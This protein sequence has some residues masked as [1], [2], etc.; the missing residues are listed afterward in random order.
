MSRE[1]IAKDLIVRDLGLVSYQQTFQQMRDFTDSRNEQTADELWVLQHH[2]VFTQGQA[3]KAEHI[4]N[5]GSV[6]IVQSDRG[7]QV[8]YHGPGQ[9]V[10]YLLFDIK[11]KHL[12]IR[13]LVDG[14]E[15]SLIR[16]LAEFSIKASAKSKAPGVYVQGKKIA[17][18]GLRVKKGRSYHGLALN[19]SMDLEPFT[20]I[21]PCGYAGLQVTDLAHLGVDEEFSVTT[22]RL[23]TQIRQN[24]G[25]HFNL[26]DA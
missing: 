19:I 13:D 17:A 26:H 3:G 24:F 14:I 12:S 11:R 2:P 16:M 6:P 25:Y 18:L 10:C 1:S 22:A 8:T 15:N 21:N 20:R 4:L 23:L 5:P 9:L 7:G